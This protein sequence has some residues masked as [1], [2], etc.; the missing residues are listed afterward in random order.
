MFLLIFEH[1]FKRAL[2]FLAFPRAFL[3]LASWQPVLGNSVLG[4][5]LGPFQSPW[6]WPRIFSES[7]ALASK[8]VSSPPPLAST[9]DKEQG[10]GRQTCKI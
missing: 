8:V 10:P 3:S 5:G 9:T 7:L 6:P 4:L 2:E 1:I